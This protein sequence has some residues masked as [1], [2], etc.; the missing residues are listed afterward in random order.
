MEEALFPHTA[1]GHGVLLVDNF[2]SYTYNIFQYLGEVCTVPPTVIKNNDPRGLDQEW[3]KQ[4]SGVVISPGPGH[5]NVPEDIGVSKTICETYGGPVLGV[6]L[7]FQ[8]MGLWGG[9]DICKAPHVVHG[10][11]A[12]VVHNGSD[13]LF[14]EIPTA[15]KVVRY[16]SLIIDPATIDSDSIELTAATLEEGDGFRIKTVPD[17][18]TERQL[19]R[20]IPMGLKMKGKPH[21]GVQYHPESICTQYGHVLIENFARICGALDANWRMNRV[22]RDVSCPLAGAGGVAF[23]SR[24]MT[25]G[26]DRFDPAAVF[27]A[28]FGTSKN[29]VWLDSTTDKRGRYSIMADTCSSDRNF[30]INYSIDTGFL[31]DSRSHLQQHAAEKVGEDILQE[32]ENLVSNERKRFTPSVEAG[33][34]PFQGGFLGYLS[35]EMRKEALKHAHNIDDTVLS[36]E[37]SALNMPD[38]SMLFAYHFVVADHLEGI[39]HICEVSENGSDGWIDKMYS[40]IENGLTQGEEGNNTV[41]AKE[42]LSFAP[43][44]NKEEYLQSIRRIKELILEGETYEVCLTNEFSC[45]LPEGVLTETLVFYKELRKINAAPYA[46]Y[47]R[48]EGYGDVCSSSPER[49]LKIDKSG[50]CEAKPIKGTMKRSD[51]PIKDAALK[52]QLIDS[53]KDQCENL[54][55]ADL[56]RNDLGMISVAGSVNVPKLMNI[57]SYKTVHQMVT[58]VRSQLNPGASHATALKVT[59]PGGSIVGAPKIRTMEFIEQLEARRR[60][61]YTGSIGCLSLCGNSDFN[62]AIR[63]AVVAKDRTEERRRILR[64][65]AGGAITILSDPEDEWDEV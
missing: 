5:P 62:I 35:Y 38:L 36:P 32:L 8:A 61:L 11:I 14:Y 30:L 54:M 50:L 9:A 44:R 57:E 37:D 12:T 47:I 31:G 24:T 13:P 6:C 39:L 48:V 21:W 34:L 10:E 43:H 29:V 22:Q 51:D 15:F 28:A 60:G 59:F 58:T 16:H 45:Q 64:I 27:T 2:D 26:E 25:F 41:A 46:A 49:F 42:K 18:L 33:H 65:G 1:A 7:G 3:V 56:I 40:K 20:V 63:T 19:E 23:H 53:V 4:F 55:I 52:Q 17:F